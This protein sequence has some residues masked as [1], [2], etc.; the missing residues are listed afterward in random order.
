MFN[1]RS[2]SQLVLLCFNAW[3]KQASW[4]GG[5]ELDKQTCFCNVQTTRSCASTSRH[6]QVRFHD[7]SLRGRRSTLNTGLPAEA[8]VARV[9]AQ[10]AN[11]LKHAARAHVSF[12]HHHKF[13]KVRP[14][15][16][17]APRLIWQ[18]MVP[19]YSLENC[20]AACQQ[21][22]ILRWGQ[23]SST[24]QQPLTWTEEQ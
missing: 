14:S 7:A 8:S 6:H 11:V 22:V 17:T 21:E 12:T 1:T 10:H 24:T 2:D 20:K 13:H 15:C 19:H 4:L 9:H 18:V 3:A 5:W 23:L 16:C